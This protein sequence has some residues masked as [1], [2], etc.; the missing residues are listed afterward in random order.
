MKRRC[1]KGCLLGK[2]EQLKTHWRDRHPAE[3]AQICRWLGETDAKIQSAAALAKEGM[4]GS[5]EHGP[6]A[7]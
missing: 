2:G 7:E 4:K 1:K 3:Y 6:R 5:Q